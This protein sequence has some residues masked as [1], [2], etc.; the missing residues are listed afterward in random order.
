MTVYVDDAI[1]MWR[2][3]RWAHLLA[4]DTDDLHRFAWALGIHRASFQEPPKSSHPHY[5][6]TA[7]DRRR[8]IALGAVPCSR[9]EIVA[10]LRRTRV[11][12]H[13]VPGS[14]R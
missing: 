11:P 7:L 12:A 14:A 9:A 6:V 3:L 10:V 2:G 13:A 5:D 1:W 4:D 8:A